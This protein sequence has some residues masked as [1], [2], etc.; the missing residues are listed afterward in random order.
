MRDQKRRGFTIVELLVV[1]A[2]ITMLMAFLVPAIMGARRA[3]RRAQCSNRMKEIATALLGYSTSKPTGALPGRLN[4]M[5]DLKGRTVF[6]D[7]PTPVDRAEPGVTWVIQILEQVD[8]ANLLDILRSGDPLFSNNSTQLPAQI[9]YTDIFICPSDLPPEKTLPYL[10]YV[11][12]SGIPDVPDPERNM[13]TVDT[14][15]NGVFHDLRVQRTTT[16]YRM[17]VRPEVDI[18]DGKRSTILLTES[19]DAGLWTSLQEVDTGIMWLNSGGT[20]INEYAGERS[21]F[22]DLTEKDYQPD[23]AL[24]YAR[25]SSNHGEGVNVAF[26]RRRRRVPSV[27]HRLSCLRATHDT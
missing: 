9:L 11:V 16:K 15:A 12:N 17:E 19:V 24:R 21:D 10:N 26:L 3:A 27:G 8:Q 1:I 5:K 4:L 18:K 25:P 23:V 2:I 7:D 14:R 6:V 20:R 13:A 22:R